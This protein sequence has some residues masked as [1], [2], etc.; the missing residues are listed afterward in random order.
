[1]RICTYL[2]TLGYVS[3]Y[4]HTSMQTLCQPPASLH[5]RV[6]IDAYALLE[7]LLSSRLAERKKAH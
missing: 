7:G 6:S 3:I 1:M 2:G 4:L 5:L